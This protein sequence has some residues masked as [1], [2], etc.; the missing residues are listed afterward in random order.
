LEIKK[1]G[2]ENM[3]HILINAGLKEIVP[4]I[5]GN[6]IKPLCPTQPLSHPTLL[7]PTEQNQ[8]LAFYFF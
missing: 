1:K 6:Y 2:C 8:L 4:V 7:S 3:H 5:I